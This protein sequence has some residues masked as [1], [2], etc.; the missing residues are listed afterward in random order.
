MAGACSQ[1]TR[2][3]CDRCIDTTC[4]CCG[5]ETASAW[6]DAEGYDWVIL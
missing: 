3:R 2:D 4:A 5:R 1:C 6:A